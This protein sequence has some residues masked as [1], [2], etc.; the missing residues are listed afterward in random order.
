MPKST[1]T[2]TKFKVDISEL[3]KNIQEA[4]RQIALANSEF[5]KAS[6]GMQSWA[7]DA[8]G[9]G[10]K[11]EQLRS[12]T[13]SYETILGELE[14]QY[15]K[16]VEKEGENSQG[17]TDLKIKINNLKAAIQGN[18]AQI[19][20]YEQAL[21]DMRK[22]Q[23]DVAGSSGEMASAS[24]KLKSTISEQESRLDA[25]KKSYVDVALEQGKDSTEARQLA[26]QIS[27]L[28]T[29]LNKNKSEL[30]NAEKAADGLSDSLDD[31][32]KSAKNAG[33]GFT[34]LKGALASLVADG[35]K[36]AA[37][38]LKNLAQ[39]SSTANNKFQAAT[40][41]S[42][43][44]M[45]NFS[46]AIEDLYKQNFGDSLEDVAEAMAQVKQQT[47]EVDPS[48]LEELTKNAMML[49]D[50]FGMDVNESMRA[51]NQ[52]MNQFGISGDEAFNLIAQGAQ[53]GLNKN[54]NLLDTINEYGPK[55]QQMGLSAD[56]MFNM[57]SNGAE[58]GVFDIDKLGDAVNEFSI[59]VK[60]GTADN[61]FKELNLDVN[62]TKEA[63]GKGGS[64]AKKAM[65][66]TMEAL[67]KVDDPL[68][69]NQLGVELF[70]TMW[71]DTGGK[72]I[73]AMGDTQGE[74]KKTKKTM[75]EINKV[76]YNDL[77]SAFSEIGRTLKVELLQPIV[78]AVLPAVNNLVG[79]IKENLPAVKQAFQDGFDTLKEWAPV[80]AG[81]G[82]AMATY[83]VVGKIQAFV[84]A[85]KSGQV[86]L[87]LMSAAQAALNAV[88][89]LNPIG[90]VIAAIAGLVAAFVILWNKSETFRNFWTGLWE[91][92][93]S[94][95][96]TAADWIVS[97][98]GS[99]VEFFTVTIPE[100]FNGVIDFVQ[101]NW[102][103]LLLLIVNPFAGAFALLYEHCG[104]FREF[105]DGFVETVKEFISKGIEATVKFFSE[106]PGKIGKFIS[107]VITNVKTWAGNMAQK[108][109]EAGSKFLTNVVNF[110]TK[111][112]GK[113]WE[114][115]TST[116]GKVIQWVAKM[117]TKAREAGSKFLSN[118]VTFFT[119][120][121]GKVWTFLTSVIGKVTTWAGN[122]VG[123]ARDAGSRF[124]ST[125]ITFF[126]QLPGKVWTWLS[127][128][129]QKAATFVT[130]F[131]QKAVEAASGFATKLISG[132]T[133]LPG[134]MVSVGGNIVD[135]IWNGIKAGWE[136]L[137]SSVSNLAGNLLKAAK[138]ALGIKSPSRKF[139]DMVGKQIPAGIAVGINKYAK[140]AKNAVSD[141]AN[142][143]MPEVDALQF[144]LD[145]KMNKSASRYN[146]VPT[147]KGAVNNYTTFNQYNNSPKALSRLEI[148]RQ[149]KNQLNFAQGVG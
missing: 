75:E 122:M 76:R 121:P 108:A 15:N 24:D 87:K 16:V 54:D 22:G 69:Q 32:E 140:L 104:A 82:A 43:K 71:E 123:K 92:V 106:L 120:L 14:S 137:T 62:A 128:T 13:S 98:F 38:A 73:L 139:R 37:G 143:L 130:N 50:T 34:V 6:A 127:N 39:E 109:T 48:K 26:A 74:I 12:V 78:E 141:M 29:E 125:L 55:F 52:L 93:Q 66:Q 145:A 90:I 84:S 35:I 40:G 105:V 31:A 131:G 5:K 100:V 114:F 9:L 27:S 144:G 7:T 51:V 118:I 126:T 59:R 99:V 102:Q 88:M 68:K 36:A 111:L 1:E 70:G 63:F 95:A 67:K 21:S 3:K 79:F 112:P 96:S 30:S 116:I 58:A 148:Y 103:S 53:S 89:S 61:A 81:I 134:Q 86:A 136:W 129:V 135:G 28:S 124:L 146:P 17:A 119:Q 60:D 83:F 44:E 97:A 2:T 4:N 107:Q 11:L 85:I 80:I 18:N 10:A 23:D 25:L 19:D 110:I 72:A 101:E 56:D 138:N 65:K 46:G 132:L 20:R 113:V 147:G 117:V 57:L 142:S 45:E 47:G 33:G 8:D 42:S 149:T 94:A 49:D 91:T 133:G 41:A 115:L 77:G 64:A